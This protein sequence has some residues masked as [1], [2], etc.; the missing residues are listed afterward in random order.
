MK[1]LL[2][3]GLALC[4]W[5]CLQ[6]KNMPVQ[7]SGGDTIPGTYATC[8]TMVISFDKSVW[9]ILQANCVSCHSATNASAG[10]DLSSYAKII[11]YVQ[12]GKLYGSITHASGY[13]PMPSATIKL[14]VCDITIIR[15]WIRGSYPSGGILVDL[16]PIKPVD[17]VVNIPVVQPPT[18][19]TCSPDTI[20][21]QQKILQ[22]M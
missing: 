18:L 1:H 20:Y 14:N 5:A 11:P 19:V 8:D 3:L 6:D 10:V 12:N 9:P 15:K 21:F 2:L 7:P 13:K 17:P 22:I 16:N 4:F